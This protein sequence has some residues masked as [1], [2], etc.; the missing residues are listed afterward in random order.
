MLDP[1]LTQILN[2][3]MAELNA[4]KKAGTGYGAF[5]RWIRGY[6]DT[7]DTQNLFNTFDT[8]LQ[9]KIDPSDIANTALMKQHEASSRYY[10]PGNISP[11]YNSAASLLMRRNK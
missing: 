10:M 6:G 11:K 8:T 5:D 4:Q 2:L 9:G 1:F 3:A 7:S